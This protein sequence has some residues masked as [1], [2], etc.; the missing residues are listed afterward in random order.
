MLKDELCTQN[1]AIEILGIDH[2][3]KFKKADI[4]GCC[5]LVPK[6]GCTVAV[7][8]DCPVSDVVAQKT[9]EQDLVVAGVGW[10]VGNFFLD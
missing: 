2:G 10:S 7:Q 3:A 4:L 6:K 9:M 1:Q 8:G 5:L